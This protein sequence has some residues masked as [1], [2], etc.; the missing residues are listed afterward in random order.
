M[1]IKQFSKIGYGL[2]I[3]F[4][5]VIGGT[6][7]FSMV[8]IEGNIQI[9]IV[10]SGSMEP[11]IKTGSVVIVKPADRYEV[12]DI[13][14]FGKDDRDNIPTTHR[15][16]DMHIISGETRFVTKGDANDD[17]DGRE[18]TE[19]S[20]IGKVLLDVP[21][22]GFILD[23]AKKPLGFAVLIGIPALVIVSDEV[24]KIYKET[25]KMRSKKEK[26]LKDNEEE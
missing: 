18:I 9:K 11:S 12:G 20:I 23:M 8:P 17:R 1:D 14:T 5:V 7:V 6:L 21:Y 22:V 13:V 15:I 24:K 26:E 4:M 10:L 25:K 16:I 2:L 19:K 3:T